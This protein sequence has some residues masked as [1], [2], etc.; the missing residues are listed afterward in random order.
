MAILSA[1]PCCT[2]THR[3]PD[4]VDAGD[5]EENSCLRQ[6]V[7]LPQGNFRAQRDDFNEGKL[8]RITAEAIVKDAPATSANAGFLERD[9]DFFVSDASRKCVLPMIF[10]PMISNP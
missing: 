7:D 10:Q 5:Q 3:Q 4:Q 8:L 9:E 6:A 1:S 2:H